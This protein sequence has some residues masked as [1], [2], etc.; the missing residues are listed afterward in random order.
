MDG[1]C[2]VCGESGM[3]HS[4]GKLRIQGA[5]SG[6][7]CASRMNGHEDRMEGRVVVEYPVLK[8]YV[9]FYS[10]VRDEITGLVL[11]ERVQAVVQCFVSFCFRYFVPFGA[12][13]MG[14]FLRGVFC[15]CV[16]CMLFV[17]VSHHTWTEC[18]LRSTRM[19][20]TQY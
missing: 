8:G 12:I 10:E 14:L 15:L 6:S 3:G 4:A 16:S 20:L 18:R 9:F 7:G 1:R 11:F 19:K 2:V 13:V 5:A 17:F